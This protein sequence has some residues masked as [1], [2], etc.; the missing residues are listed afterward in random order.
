MPRVEG[1]S[2]K[3]QSCCGHWVQGTRAPSSPRPEPGGNPFGLTWPDATPL[4]NVAV[5]T[6]DGS[7]SNPLETL[8]QAQ[9]GNDDF[10]SL[11]ISFLVCGFSIYEFLYS[12]LG[13]GGPFSFFLF[14]SF[15]FFPETGEIWG[16]EGGGEN[17]SIVHPRGS[18]PKSV[19]CRL[20]AGGPSLSSEA[21]S[22]ASALQS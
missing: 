11:R 5:P 7:R 20:L 14:F 6:P 22:T 19:S 21:T 16:R 18:L 13:S 3:Q 2:P 1:P 8:T 9:I 12:L 4:S 10:F 17:L 15:C